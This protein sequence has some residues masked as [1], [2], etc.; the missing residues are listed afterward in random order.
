VRFASQPLVVV[1]VFEE[2]S[3]VEIGRRRRGAGPVRFHHLRG[4]GM[5]LFIINNL[6]SEI[7]K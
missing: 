6:I 4:D 7:I 3:L 5:Y 1:S 2:N